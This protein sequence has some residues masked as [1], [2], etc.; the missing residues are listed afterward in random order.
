MILDKHN[1]I[2]NEMKQFL[3]HL[4]RI[5]C[6]VIENERK[7]LLNHFRNEPNRLLSMIFF[8]IFDVD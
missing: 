6:R 2:K 7:T 5:S 3:I 1:S 4:Q 8:N